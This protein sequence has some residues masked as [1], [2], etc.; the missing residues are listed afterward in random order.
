MKMLRYKCEAKAMVPDEN[1]MPVEQ[2]FL[3][4]KIVK[5]DERGRA[6]AEAE[7]VGEIVAYDDG[8]AEPDRTTTDDVLNALLGVTV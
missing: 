2:T 5:D 1:G 7:A 4:T 3:R 6:L 8:R